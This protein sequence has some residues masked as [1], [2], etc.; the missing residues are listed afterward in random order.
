MADSN[1]KCK[2]SVLRSTNGIL[3]SYSFDVLKVERVKIN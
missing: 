3:L 1:M 2:R